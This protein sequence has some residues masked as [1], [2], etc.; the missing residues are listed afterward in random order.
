ML[1]YQETYKIDRWVFDPLIPFIYYLRQLGNI[2]T[3]KI[4]EISLEVKMEKK[5]TKFRA[6]DIP[7]T[8]ITLSSNVEVSVLV[9]WKSFDPF[10]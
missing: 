10:Y 7:D 6:M 9:L 3:C 1:A 5:D 4:S 2:M 8:C